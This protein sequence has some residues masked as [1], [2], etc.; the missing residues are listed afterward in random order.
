[1]VAEG[2]KAIAEE[3]QEKSAEGATGFKRGL[4]A[5]KHTIEDLTRSLREIQG[6]LSDTRESLPKAT[7]HL[8]RISSQTEQ[9]THKVLDMVE[10][11]S[12]QQVEIIDHLNK[13]LNVL[14]DSGGENTAVSELLEKA[15]EVANRSQNDAFAIMD[16]LQ[17]Q[18]ITTQQINHAASLLEDVDDKIAQIFGDIDGSI[19]GVQTETKAG[20]RKNRQDRSFDPHADMEIKHTDQSDIDSLV[21]ENNGPNNSK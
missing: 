5:L 14:S 10:N 6:P 9:A 21:R 18:D 11:I 16:A 4:A 2:N 8:D 19:A 20:S 17:F 7:T 12:N 15:E 3:H 1:M 13:A